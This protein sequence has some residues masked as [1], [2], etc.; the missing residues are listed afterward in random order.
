MKIAKPRE[1]HLTIFRAEWLRHRVAVTRS[2]GDTDRHRMAYLR[3]LYL[4]LDQHEG[5][6]EVQEFKSKIRAL[7]GESRKTS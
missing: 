1:H 6:D 5:I 3:K 4:H 2:P 7:A